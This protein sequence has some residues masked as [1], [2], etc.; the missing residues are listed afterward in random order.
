MALAADRF[1]RYRDLNVNYGNDGPR[2]FDDFSDRFFIQPS[3]KRETTMAYSQ[4]ISRDCRGVFIFLIDQSRSM[5]KVFVQDSDGKEISRAQVVAD[6]V[7]R[8]VEELVNRCM[9]DEGV[10]DYFDIAVI[11]YGRTNRPEFCW[12]GGL[13]GRRLVP[14]SEV[15]EKAELVESQIVTMIRGKAVT[16][17]VTVSTWIKPVAE[18]STPMNGALRLAHVTLHDWIGKNPNSYPPVIINITDG[19]ANDVD[20]DAE[21][22]ETARGLTALHT[23]D[24]NVLLINCH[25]ADGSE[26]SVVFPETASELPGDPY[27]RLLFDM[28]SELTPR[29]RAVICEL[30]DRDLGTASM[31]GVAYNA[32]AIALVKLLDI[33]TRPAIL[34]PQEALATALTDRA[35]AGAD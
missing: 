14:I 22:L 28:S 18:D 8:T 13:A 19:M 17:R 5:N 33:G 34:A 11:G 30:F 31:R 16:E 9:R 27:A 24:G 29:H 26:G 23:T 2:W 32:D 25:I 1:H 15:A 3:Y 6:A 21:L 20:T 12:Q 4:E 35:G 7:N 10:R